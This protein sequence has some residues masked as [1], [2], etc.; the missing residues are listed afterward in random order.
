MSIWDRLGD[1]IT[2]V[3]SSTSSGVAD[4][5]EAVRT[6]F[7][8]DPDLRRRVAFSVAMIALSAKMAK[9]DGIVTQDEVRAFQQIFE[10][11]KEQTRNVARLYDLAK[12]DIAG[13]ET[14]A[15][16]M[17]QLCGSGH[18]NCKMLEDIVDGLFHIA[19]ADG[20]V[21]EREGRFLHRIAE[22]FRIEEAHYQ[23]ILARHVDL[24]AADPY[25]VLGIERGKTFEEVRK[26]YRKLVS[27]NHPDR[28]IARG[29]PQEF[30]KIATSRIAAINAA[31][32]MIER[33]L[34]HA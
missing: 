29:L 25:V 18:P 34:R 15:A 13:F 24:G 9:A 6:V 27:D 4:V 17:A 30:I 11:P 23:T 32:E 19:K 20:L 14:Y 2:R 7:S 28:L 31:Y 21:H 16:R 3:S 12:R 10:V 22:I 8:G 1:F 5:V 33:G 26:R